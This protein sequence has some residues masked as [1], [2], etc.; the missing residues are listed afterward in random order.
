M[1]EAHFTP[2]PPITVCVPTIGRTATL[3]TT[4]ESLKAQTYSNYEVLILD[5]ASPSDT[6]EE[7]ARYVKSER[8]A[9][10]LRSPVQLPMFDNFQRGVD[11]ATGQYVTFFHDDDVY[12]Q[13]FLKQQV[14]LL[15]ANL[16]AGFSGSNWNLIDGDGHPIGN[17]NLI[18]KTEVWSGWHYI[19]ALFA[20]GSNVLPMPGVVFRQRVLDRHTFASHK[21]AHFSD[22]V[23]LMKIA[24]DHD[25]GLIARQLITLRSHGDQASRQLGVVDSL[26]LRTAIFSKYCDDLLIRHP[27]RSKYVSRLRRLIRSA[28]RSSAIWTWLQAEDTREA[29]G[30]RLALGTEGMDLWIGYGLRGADQLGLG[31]LL[32]TQRVQRRVKNLA[33]FLAARTR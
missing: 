21:G 25:V 23:I 29:A 26:G 18:N 6:Q 31:G 30:A 3:M 16:S 8:R 24:E 7:I 14:Q 10:V 5:N 28:R 19:E 13:N 4:L 2:E 15:E 32:R 27:D 12:A 17:R 22:F 11:A 9:S 1:S 33:Y 20:L